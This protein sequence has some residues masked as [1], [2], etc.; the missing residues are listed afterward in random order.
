MIDIESAL[1]EIPHFETFCSVEKLR[2]LVQRLA[3]DS[4]FA[5]DIS[6]ESSNGVPINHVRFGRGSIKAL[7]VGFPHCMEPIGGL[8]VFS[9]MTLLQQGSRALLDADV[10][11][12]I[13]PC[14]DPD[15]ALLNEGWSQKPFTFESYMRNYYLQAPQDQVDNSFPVVHKKL[16]WNKPSRE[17]KI[18]EGVLEWVQP[19][20][21]FSLHNAL[22]GGAWYCLSRDIDRKYYRE[23]HK[24][25]EK[26]DF[27]IQKNPSWREVCA[28]FG[29]GIEEIVSIRKI[30]DYLER[31]TAS[32]EQILQSGA[33]SWDYLAQIKPG[34]LTFVAEM[35]YVRHPSDA[36][37]MLTGRNLRQFKLEVDADSKFIATVL[38]EEWEK[39]KGDLDST[40]PFY[41]AMVGG[42][43]PSKDK[44]MEGSFP[45]SRYSTR[46]TLFNPKYNRE[47]TEGERFDACMV[48]GGFRFLLSSY[49][50]VRLLKSSPRTSAVQQAIERMERIFSEAL[51]GI[52][53]YVDL[54]AFEA[55]D[56]DTLARLQL[57][58][59]LIVLNSLL[60]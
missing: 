51:S 38:L 49:Q 8:T 6:G 45:L 27:P 14:I 31:T 28:H 1:Q 54:E 10:E 44:L 16:V 37:E 19:D 24:L 4:R 47:M 43:L 42:A 7:F 32:P 2:E 40:S 12:H 13:V 41:R 50:F 5:V 22:T 48:D 36:S 9:L 35:G 57:G 39:V 26:Y 59:G 33:G 52:D 58:S 56:C 30:Y 20:F 18:L 53:D 3:L 29:E 23:I 11:W 46:D 55:I 21:F 17:A 60:E 25:L 34:A 15:G